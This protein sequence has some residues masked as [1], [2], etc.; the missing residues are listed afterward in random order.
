MNKTIT[1]LY[2]TQ[3]PVNGMS[4][5]V[6]GGWFQKQLDSRG[7]SQADFHRRSGLPRSTISTWATGQRLPDPESVD[8]IADVFG[9]PV[10][11]V[12]TIAGHRPAVEPLDANDPRQLL[13]ARVLRTRLNEDDVILLNRMF[14]TWDERNRREREK[15]KGQAMSAKSGAAP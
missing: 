3:Y 15:G 8:L 10:D 2:G 14:D 13:A 1:P 6:F 7:W 4:T 5:A 9:L 11:T 12:L